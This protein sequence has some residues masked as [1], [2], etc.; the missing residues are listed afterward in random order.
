MPRKKAEERHIRKLIKLGNGSI[1]VTIPIEDVRELGWKEKHKV[2]V[3]RERGAMVIRD[4]KPSK[5]KNK[6]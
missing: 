1:A 3:K 2:T 4:T 5:N 6:K